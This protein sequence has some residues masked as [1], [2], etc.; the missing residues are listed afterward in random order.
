ML[1][2]VPLT[3]RAGSAS[4]EFRPFVVK[5]ARFVANGF[6]FCAEIIRSL[7]FVVISCVVWPT[8]CGVGHTYFSRT[9]NG[10]LA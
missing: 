6:T 9:G 4:D 7:S 1:A 3:F 2:M 8:R 5:R 10:L